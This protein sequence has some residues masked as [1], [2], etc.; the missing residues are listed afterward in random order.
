M[1][2]LGRVHVA[3]TRI[4]RRYPFHAALLS[5]WRIAADTGTPTMGV[6]LTP[7][8]VLE[9]FYSPPFVEAITIEELS[10][11]VLH[12]INHVILGHLS[13]DPADFEKHDCLVIAME[14]TAN[15]FV[16]GPLPG[17]PI[18]LGDYRVLKPDQS[19]AERYR[20]L[21]AKS[22]ASLAASSAPGRDISEKRDNLADKSDRLNKM[23]GTSQSS[24]NTKATGGDK[25]ADKSDASTKPKADHD[26]DQG[27]PEQCDLSGADVPDGFDARGD[28]RPGDGTGG[29]SDCQGDSDHEGEGDGTG[30]MSSGKS[31]RQGAGHSDG[32]HNLV[33]ELARGEVAAGAEGDGQSKREGD[34]GDLSDGP[35]QHHPAEDARRQDKPLRG[36]AEMRDGGSNGHEGPPTLDDHSRWR[37]QNQGAVEHAI[38]SDL[39]AAYDALNDEAQELVSKGLREA[40][41]RQRKKLVG[42]GAGN[43]QAK[44]RGRGRREISSWSA[45]NKFVGSCLER[46]VSYNYPSR[47]APELLGIVPGSRRMPSKPM[48]LAAIDTSGSMTLRE[49]ETISAELSYLATRYD[50]T[51]VECDAAIQRTYRYTKPILSVEGG[52]GT[53]FRPLFERGFLQRHRPDLVLVFTDGHGPAPTA[54]PQVPVIWII[55][56]VATP[57]PWG[58]V[59]RYAGTSPRGL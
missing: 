22:P 1:N 21:A 37:E 11:V 13:L 43:A 46:A 56:T 59:M 48:I 24:S 14:V 9:L 50:I 40:I 17:G 10:N 31:D 12:E 39:T 32:E 58:L 35:T 30:S 36:S 27:E 18:L 52:G 47:R 8:L 16:D 45:L 3:V 51:V 15:E 55:S 6:R 19:T 20:I 7:S 49:L 41:D 42:V 2:V 4:A 44:L 34:S 29:E 28:G 57:A 38:A 53:D 54:P 26:V 25:K 23:A 33:R 5:K